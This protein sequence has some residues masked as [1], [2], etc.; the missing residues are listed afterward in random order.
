M[1]YMRSTCHPHAF[2][3]HYI[4]QFQAY[5]FSEFTKYYIK[6]IDAYNADWPLPTPVIHTHIHRGTVGHALV[7]VIMTRATTTWL[8][9]ADND[10]VCYCCCC[11]QELWPVAG[12]GAGWCLKN[13]WQQQQSQHTVANENDA[14]RMG[15]FISLQRACCALLL[16]FLL[17]HAQLAHIPHTHTH[18]QTYT[19]TSTNGE[20]EGETNSVDDVVA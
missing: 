20:R 9:C 17:I 2:H 8:Q 14:C 15:N 1:L 5:C 4:T 11:S 18:T 7:T 16:S 10:N 19:G 6:H 3:T 13:Q 12:Q